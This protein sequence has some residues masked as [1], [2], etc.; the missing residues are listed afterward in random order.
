MF[1]ANNLVVFFRYAEGNGTEANFGYVTSLVFLSSTKL[2][3]ADHFNHCLRLIDL[4]NNPPSTTRFAGLCENA[5]F[6]QG[7]RLD[8]ARL[9]FPHYIDIDSSGSPVYF[10]DNSRLDLRKINLTTDDVIALRSFAELHT[11]LLYYNNMLYFII[12]YAKVSKIDLEA[13]DDEIVIAGG[14]STGNATG[15]LAETRFYGVG[16]LIGWPGTQSEVLLVA[17]ENNKRYPL[18]I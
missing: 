4:I 2:L 18:S 17:D 1:I 5:G 10:I 14:D 9:K 3:A 11:E 16:D 7:H 8:R 6:E 12:N 15:S 13:P